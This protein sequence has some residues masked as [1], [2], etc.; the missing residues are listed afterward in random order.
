MADT[1][2]L[3]ADPAAKPASAVKTKGSWGS[4]IVSVFSL[5]LLLVALLFAFLTHN[6]NLLVILAGVIATNSTTI[7]GFWVGSSLSSQA[8]DA[9]ISAQLPTPAPAAVAPR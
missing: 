9:T 6:D 3:P 2:P 7:I 8:K 1:E 5:A 4:T